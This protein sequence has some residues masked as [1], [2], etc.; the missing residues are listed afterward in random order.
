M[1]TTR[2]V[3]FILLLSILFAGCIKAVEN[4]RNVSKSELFISTAASLADALEEI[5]QIYETENDVRLIFNYRGSGKLAQQIQQG[6]PVDVFISANTYWM[7]VL[8]NE[9]YIREDTLANI[10]EN[11]LVLITGK[12][13]M[14]QY[15][16]I[17]EI[18]EQDVEQIAIGNPASVPA[19]EYAESILK[20]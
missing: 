5:K 7:D 8:T 1:R 16:S 13:L 15:H 12:D 17:A 9:N 6:A 3:L 4:D 11:K 18:N 19:G 14:L 10:V 2:L 20:V